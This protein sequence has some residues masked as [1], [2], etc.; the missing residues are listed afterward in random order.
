MYFLISLGLTLPNSRWNND[1]VQKVS[2]IKS[3]FVTEDDIYKFSETGIQIDLI[4]YDMCSAGL[5]AVTSAEAR[6]LMLVYDAI[7]Q[8]LGI[9]LVLSEL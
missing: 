1:F 3:V 9:S 5:T 8:M 7:I 4:M 6:D 2:S